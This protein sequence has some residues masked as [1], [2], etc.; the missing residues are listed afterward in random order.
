MVG[1]FADGRMCYRNLDTGSC[2]M[3]DDATDG[4]VEGQLQGSGYDA[5]FVP[6]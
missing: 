5:Q 2:V 1:F 3:Y 4:F 6:L